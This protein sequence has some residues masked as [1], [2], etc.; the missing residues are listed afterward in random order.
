MADILVADDTRAI[1]S[2]LSILLEEEGHAVRLAANGLEALAE[3]RKKRPDLLLLDVMMPKKNGYQVLRQ[4][5][6]EDPALPVMILSAKGSPADV[7]WGLD[8]GSDDY[9]PKPFSN[10]VLISRINA[11]FRRMNVLSSPDPAA[12]PE[13]G[14]AVASYWVD[15]G[16][17]T[18]VDPNGGEEALSLREINML[19]ILTG[20]ANEV[21]SRD[22]LINEVWGV[23]YSGTSRTLDQHV[24]RLRKKL[25]ADGWCLETMRSA[26]YRYVTK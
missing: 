4:I 1:R 25:G 2:A 19:R 23:G 18:L 21:V 13:R 12:K 9:L 22:R 6:E 10:E 24:F 11:I 7:A 3:Y 5:R 26:G 14:F 17:L 15:T 8:L 20:H 16:R